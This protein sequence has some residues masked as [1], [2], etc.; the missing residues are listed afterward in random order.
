M[1]NLKKVL[2][3]VLVVATLMGFATIASAAKFSDASS[4]KYTEAVDVM[5]AVGVI[6][7]YTDGTFRPTANVTRGQTAKMVTFI[8]NKGTDV[9]NLYASANTFTDCTSNWAKGYIAY[10]SKTG[11]VAGI[12]GGKFNPN[13]SVTGT[14]A[15]K[16]LLCALGYDATIEGYTGSNWSVNVLNDAD[17]AGLLK[18]LSGVDMS[19]ALTREQ[20][21]QMMFNALKANMVKYSSKGS[22]IVINGVTIAQGASDAEAVT[23]TKGEGTDGQIKKDGIVQFA[24]KYFTDLK[25]TSA[26]TDDFGRPAVTWKNKTTTIGTYADT[27]TASYTAEVN[28]KTI[29]ADLGLSDSSKATLVDVYKNV[30]KTIVLAKKDT[31]VIDNSG[32]GVLTEVFMDADDN[33]SIVLVHTFADTVKSTTAAKNGD[34][35][36]VTLV[37]G[38]KYETE[39]FA[40]DDVV[41]YTAISASEAKSM[42]KAEVVK[43]VEVTKISSDSFTAGGTT[44][45]FSAD[46]TSAN[47]ANVKLNST[48]D[49]YLDAYGYVILVNVNKDAT[50]SAYV[51]DTGVSSSTFNKDQYAKLLLTDGTL[52]EAKVTKVGSDTATTEKVSKLKGYIVE[53]SKNKDNEYTLTSYGDKATK[54]AD[55]STSAITVKKGESAMALG[56]SD[57]TNYANSKTIFLVQTGTE[58]KP[59]YTAYTGYANVPSLKAT[60]G[61]YSLYCETGTVAS[62]V[63]VKGATATSSNKDIVLVLGS[64]AATEVNDKDLGTYYEYPAVINGKAE[65]I[66]TNVK[67]LG[68]D[69]LY[70]SIVYNTD[71]I[72]QLGESDGSSTYSVTTTDDTYAILN[73]TIS[74]AA[75]N[76]TLGVA[77]KLYALSSSAEV[78]KVTTKDSKADKVESDVIGNVEK[79]MT[80]TVVVKNGEIVSVFYYVASTSTPGTPVTDTSIASVVLNNDKTITLTLKGI[81]SA[82]TKYTADLQLWNAATAEYKSIQSVELTIA[83]GAKT[84][85][86]SA[87]PAIAVGNM[88]KVVVSG[89]ASQPI[90]IT[91]SGL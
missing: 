18:N 75:E 29:Y 41:L 46:I 34:A 1:K 84:V 26:S 50:A 10:A 45:K 13:G 65:T 60:A 40:K 37:G 70:S 42:A 7:G 58:S 21:A 72:A 32:N 67:T 78:W 88:Y 82:D 61:T 23:T 83:K 38:L 15:A 79:D 54:T 2:A 91:A 24:E 48:L 59:V 3:L 63:F 62:I 76:S 55:G 20:A 12:G 39:S 47:K 36:Y 17:A 9:G 52:V 8:L 68:S 77:S 85:T 44:Y 11:I 51:V 25:K 71:G 73:A 87:L 56:S 22:S 90:T 19:K 64:K 5:K 57:T 16:M 30:D 6:D 66:K 14:Q 31:T 69:K 81:V 74:A 80:A 27:A 86:S 89:V 43:G 33:I 49:L 53:F 35:A 28:Y 4:I